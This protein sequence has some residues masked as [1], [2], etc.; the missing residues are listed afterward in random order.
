M[1]PTI[2][3]VPYDRVVEKI[4]EVPVER[5]VEVPID[6]VVVDTVE[7]PVPVERIVERVV[8][9]PQDKIIQVCSLTCLF[10]ACHTLLG[11]N[12]AAPE[13]FWPFSSHKQSNFLQ[14]SGDG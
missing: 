4:V 5:I 6:R 9:V 11:P 2:S 7:V 14:L 3:Q 13:F 12:P 10:Y 8:E 1:H